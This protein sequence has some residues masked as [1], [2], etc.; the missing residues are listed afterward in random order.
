[1]ELKEVAEKYRDYITE[2]RRWFHAHPEVSGKE[3]NT[4]SAIKKELDDA[5]I[6]WRPCGLETGVLATI[7]GARPGRTVLIRGDIDALTVKEETGLDYASENEGVMHACG[8]DSHIA[9]LL[10]AARI[11][12]DLKSELCGTVKLAF[13]PAEETAQG[14][15]SMIEQGALDGVDGCFGMH[16]WSGIP[17]GKISIEPGPR[18]AS[19]DEFKID[20]QGKGGHGAA[21]H[22]CVDAAIVSSAIVGNLQTIVS[23]EIDPVDPAVLTVGVMQVGTR[24]NV[25]SEYGHLEGTTRCFSREVRERFPEMMERIVTDTA[26]T[27]RAEAKLDY[28]WLVPPTINEET[29]TEI[30]RQ[31]AV[32]VMGGDAPIVCP[33]TAGGEDFAFFLEKVPGAI[34]LLGAGSEACGAVW[35]Q[36]SGKFRIDESVLISGAMLHA[37][38]AMDFNAK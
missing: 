6:P 36:H 11:L 28:I 30:A 21:P 13:Q 25:V 3:Y 2:K 18:M 26:K 19:G 27:F 7:E 37:Q 23:R 24:W 17:A 22:L 34:A 1:L 8:H 32:K 31:S 5:G 14:A 15:K 10:G 12:N 33:K 29:V 4:S 16:I 35:P 20:V 38:V 9:M